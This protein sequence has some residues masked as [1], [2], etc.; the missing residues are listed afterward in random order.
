MHLH[1]SSPR[2]P[3]TCLLLAAA[4]LTLT[5]RPALC[6]EAAPRTV[7]AGYMQTHLRG[8]SPGGQLQLTAYI[9]GGESLPQLALAGQTLG[10]T[11]A[12]QGGGIYQLDQA[13]EALPAGKVLLELQLAGSSG[14][15]TVWPYLEVSPGGV[16]TPRPTPLPVIPESD[17]ACNPLG[18]ENCLLPYPSSHYLK[19]DKTTKT[20]YRVHVPELA[21]PL[22]NDPARINQLDGWG[23]TSTLLAEFPGE[24]DPALI[25]AFTDAETSLLPD[26]RFLLYNIDAASPEFGHQHAVLVR[27]VSNG[28]HTGVSLVPAEAL[29][30]GTRYLVALRDL[31][32]P[33]GERVPTSYT[34]TALRDGYGWQTQVGPA[35][36]AYEAMFDFLAAR[37]VARGSIDLLWDF[38]T[39]SSESLT[40]PLLWMVD[41]AV[42]R[43]KPEQA[44]WEVIE[45]LEGR[46]ALYNCTLR[47]PNFVGFDKRFVL[48]ARGYPTYLND[49]YFRFTVFVPDSALDRDDGPAPVVLFGHGMGGNAEAARSWFLDHYGFVGVA[50]DWV[51]LQMLDY[52]DFATVALT[53]PVTHLPMITDRLMQSVVNAT[54]VSL[55]VPQI[56]TMLDKEF[57]RPILDP[58][59]HYYFGESLGGIMGSMVMAV[60][61]TI[62]AGALLVPGGGLIHLI[63]ETEFFNMDLGG[64][65]FKDV[66]DSVFADPIEQQLIFGMMQSGWDRVDP[67]SFARHWSRE[68][69]G[70]RQPRHILMQEGM[71]DKVVPN[72]TTHFLLSASGLPLLKPYQYR[73]PGVPLAD[74]PSLGAHYGGCFQF[75]DGGHQAGSRPLARRQQVAFYRSLWDESAGPYGNIIK[76]EP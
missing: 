9:P 18:V 59:R 27:A 58:Q 25:P 7:L 64:M 54:M 48:D 40:G 60:H 38:H 56:G 74:S 39:A 30:P 10:Y 2:V 31:R 8:G 52:V 47:G 21:M 14:K 73:I 11:L 72:F 36:P 23:L 44:T 62:P 20:G 3:R 35:V 4:L 34:F 13:M 26:S 67:A 5:A 75:P 69:L 28:T 46:G 55:L 22:A 16:Q 70:N 45:R 15:S 6:Q 61:P 12:A 51:G 76:V 57:G 37:G 66:V 19:R 41:E 68:P 33:E 71:V 50:V 49:S 42:R 43:F 32:T 63:Q 17:N 53:G 1:L 29:E 65:T 24:V